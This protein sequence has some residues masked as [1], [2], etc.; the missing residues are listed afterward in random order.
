MLIQLIESQLSEKSSRDFIL[1]GLMA[2]IVFQVQAHSKLVCFSKVDIYALLIVYGSSSKPH[3]HLNKEAW[4]ETER[5]NVTCKFGWGTGKIT[6]FIFLLN[7][8]GRYHSQRCH[9]CLF[10]TSSFLFYPMHY[11]LLLVPPFPIKGNVIYL[12]SVQLRLMKIL[13]Y[14]LVEIKCHLLS[15][16][17]NETV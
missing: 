14:H 15:L 11:L 9:Q 13:K 1:D 6:K 5:N 3:N 17:K 12:P 16:Y 7:G 4:E 10:S 8:I 2:E